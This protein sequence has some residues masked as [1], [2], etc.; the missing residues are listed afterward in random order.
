MRLGEISNGSVTPEAQGE[1]LRKHA[2]LIGVVGEEHN[3]VQV[4][5]YEGF[6]FKVYYANDHVVQVDKI[7]EEEA[8]IYLACSNVKFGEF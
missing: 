3:Y 6:G 5:T 8:K 2:H 4:Y 7:G 1:Y